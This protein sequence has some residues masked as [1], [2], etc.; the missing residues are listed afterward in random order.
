[1]PSWRSS[2]S[3]IAGSCQQI[4]CSWVARRS[5]S[6][7]CALRA[8]ADGG[9][10]TMKAHSPLGVTGW[11]GGWRAAVDAVAQYTG[12][13]ETDRRIRVV[14]GFTYVATL[15]AVVVNIVNLFVDPTGALRGA[16]L[17]SSFGLVIYGLKRG[18]PPAAAAHLL[19]ASSFAVL[20]LSLI[21]EGGLRA[22][23]VSVPP[24][25]VVAAALLLPPRSSWIWVV[26][27][28]GGF[29]AHGATADA[30]QWSSEFNPPVS[31]A[32]THIVA[33]LLAYGLAMLFER[34]RHQAYTALA[35][36]KQEVERKH[37]QLE[38]TVGQLHDTQAELIQARKME[39]VGQLAAG[40]AH[41]INTP[42]QYVRDNVVFLGEAVDDL[43][44][45]VEKLGQET[46]SAD[47]GS[48][49]A[50]RIELLRS[51]LDEADVEF[52]LEAGPEA[53]SDA[54]D[55]IDRI[56]SIIIAM[57]QRA[58]PAKKGGEWCDFNQMI[59]GACE[60]IQPELGEDTVLDRELAPS[61]PEV[62]CHPSDV[63]QALLN[64]LANAAQA[65]AEEQVTDQPGRI[66][67]TTAQ[68][69]DAVEVSVTDTGPGMTDDIRDRIFDPFF[70]T[71]VVGR[72]I[73]A[74]LS[75]VYR[76]VVDDHGG[77]VS[78]NS[79]PGEGATLV[80]RFPLESS[81]LAA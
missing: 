4:L 75:L 48:L 44:T 41:E 62:L 31:Y 80:L 53:A 51:A 23:V 69:G 32:T 21:Q 67:V 15:A 56:R 26:A 64:V 10:R 37:I 65:I 39:A 59:H 19:M 50:E 81:P 66:T 46:S 38:E 25:G 58:A 73:G 34:A 36:E 11:R 55:G 76:I 71:R 30:T 78:C 45:V 1:M 49:S 5:P 57:K 14:I 22:A 2:H 40:A 3:D 6:V 8:E 16:A 13:P 43:L 29:V 60:L 79:R 54:L 12:D 33:V 20:Q 72:G 77:T 9:Q 35:A 52:L 27:W 61:L 7:P 63:Q 24:A 28:V 42:A 68:V 17:L 18:M 74:G 47:T 70:T